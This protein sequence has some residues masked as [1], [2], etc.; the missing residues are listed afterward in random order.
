MELL[1]NDGNKCVWQVVGYHFIEELKD[2]YG[3]ELQGFDFNF[4]DKD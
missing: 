3:I 4:F 2:N 1:G